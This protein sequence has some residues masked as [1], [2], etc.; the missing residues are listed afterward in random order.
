MFQSEIEYDVQE[1]IDEGHIDMIITALVVLKTN[2]FFSRLDV[3]N[4]SDKEDIVQE[5]LTKVAC[6]IRDNPEKLVQGKTSPTLHTERL[7]IC[8]CLLILHN[9]KVDFFRRMKARKTRSITSDELLIASSQSEQ[10]FETISHNEQV[11]TI[12]R[13]SELTSIEERV[14]ELRMD[15]CSHSEVAET[16]GISIDQSKKYSV[17]ANRKLKKVMQELGE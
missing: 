4:Q 10:P 15:G 16:L 11:D 7:L 14:R 13:S 2:L 8:F 17:K 9:V 3:D 6:H 12:L 1:A 5:M